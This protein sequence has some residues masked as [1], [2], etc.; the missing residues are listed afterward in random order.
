[1]K[2]IHELS[3]EECRWWMRENNIKEFRA[4]QLY[5]W[6]WKRN[7]RSFR[8]MN[9]LP[10]NLKILL[11]KNFEI[12]AFS[13][14]E[15]QKSSDGSI[16]YG[17]R[18]SDG[19][20]IEMVLIPSGHRITV[21]VSSQVGC[22]LNCS[23]CATAKLGFHRNLTAY[24]MYSQVFFAKEEAMRIYNHTLSNVVWMGMGEPLLNYEEVVKAIK[25][26]VGKEGLE[27]SPSRIT[28]STSGI[29]EGIINLARENLRINLAI[30]L[31]TADPVQRSEIMPVNRKYP[32][33]A[34]SDALNFYHKKT[35]DR[36]TIE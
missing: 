29:C 19:E 34:L 35:S 9:N 33:L 6:L 4:N 11:E 31:H 8:E 5:E 16:K 1:M 36:I 12:H 24:E 30:S 13:V 28:V 20:L 15:I 10:S 17:L 25:K 14:A 21:C 26:V 3:L 2:E 23:F 32:L 7:V 27:M 22:P 18:L